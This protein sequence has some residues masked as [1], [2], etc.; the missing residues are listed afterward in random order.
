MMRAA[1][2][3]DERNRRR[4]VVAVVISLLIHFCAMLGIAVVKGVRPAPHEPEAEPSV[5]VTMIEPEPTPPP[6]FVSST[7]DRA[8]DKVPENPL[9]ESDKNMAAASQLPAIGTAPLPTTQGKESP[10]LELDDQK[11]TLGKTPAESVPAQPPRPQTAIQ[12]PVAQQQPTVKMPPVEKTADTRS[13]ETKQAEAKSTPPP[14]TQLALLDPPASSPPKPQP[15]QSAAPREL[16]QP[17]PPSPPSRQ[18]YQPETRTTRITGSISNRGRPSVAALAT[19]LG[20]YKKM[21]SDAIGSRWYYYVNDQ[22]GLLSIG[23]VEVRFIVSQSG[24]VQGIRVLSNTSNESFAA[25]SVNAIA[26]AE[27]PPIPD[28]VAKLLNNGRIE[29]DYTF[30][31]LGN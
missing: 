21:V 8:T 11:Y 19:P 20:R 28:D 24:K 10:N 22:M 9:F 29:I 13:A 25:C 3:W 1:I 12:Q 7:A 2:F 16:Q 30:T 15:M 31:I 26:D 17:A 23:T 6:T 14:P 27:I 4:I 5:Q 18:G